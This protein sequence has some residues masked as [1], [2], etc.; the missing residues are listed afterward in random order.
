MNLTVKPQYTLF[1]PNTSK[2][3]FMIH[4]TANTYGSHAPT[5]PQPTQI[6]PGVPNHP[7]HNKPIDDM[8]A[9]QHQA[10]QQHAAMAGA[11]AVQPQ[12][13]SMHYSGHNPMSAQPNLGQPQHPI[14]DPTPAMND[15]GVQPVN[16]PQ[17]AEFA[18]SMVFLMWHARRPSVLA[19]YNSSNTTSPVGTPPSNASPTGAGATASG[20][21]RQN[22]SI[23]SSASPAFKKFC[24]NLLGFFFFHLLLCAKKYVNAKKKII[25]PPPK[26]QSSRF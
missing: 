19:L 16:I 6:P 14:P 11:A 13:P 22:I 1:A 8:M 18:S 15:H 5:Y 9:Q 4:P 3:L 12:H 23:G 17:L 24:L 10:R 7:Y 26:S 25:P 20:Q 21:H 2:Q